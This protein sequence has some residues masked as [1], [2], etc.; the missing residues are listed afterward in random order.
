MKDV[1]T[2]FYADGIN[3]LVHRYEKFVQMGGDYVEK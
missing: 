1:G 3:K 2:Q